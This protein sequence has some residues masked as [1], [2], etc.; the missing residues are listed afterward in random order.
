MPVVGIN[1]S[2]NKLESSSKTKLCIYSYNSRGFSV[3]KQNFCSSLFNL[4]GD[5]LPILCNQENFLY[6]SSSYKV[7]QALP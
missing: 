6:G 3:E 7:K 2:F 4:T 1:F 5:Y